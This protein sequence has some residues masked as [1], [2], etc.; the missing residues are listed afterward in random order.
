MKVIQNRGFRRLKIPLLLILSAA[1][2]FSACM[3][4][5]KAERRLLPLR[6][7][8]EFRQEDIEKF[9]RDDP[10]K[11]IHLIG[12]YRKLYGAESVFPEQKDPLLPAKIDS[13]ETRAVENLKSAQV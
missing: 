8:G 9:V 11:A 3:T 1:L 5:A 10:V 13:L 12:M 6:S 7:T 4:P 2:V